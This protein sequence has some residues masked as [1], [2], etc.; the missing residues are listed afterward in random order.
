MW[1][2]TLNIGAVVTEIPPKSPSLCVDRS[3][4]RYALPA[5]ELSGKVWTQRDILLRTS[6]VT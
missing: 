4:T 6:V 1:L 2:S 5:Q 3:P